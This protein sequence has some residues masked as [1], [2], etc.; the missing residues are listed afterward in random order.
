MRILF[1]TSECAPFSKSGGLADEA[2]SLPPAL[3]KAGDEIS[4]ITLL[5]RC[6]REGFADQ[7][8]FVMDVRVSLG[9]TEYE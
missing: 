1:V 9:K 7:T 6:V 2:F 5:Y 4:V 8:E 3:K